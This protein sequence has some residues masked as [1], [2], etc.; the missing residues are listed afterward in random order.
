MWKKVLVITFKTIVYILFLA[1]L[2]A[3]LAKTGNMPAAMPKEY[4]AK[5]VEWTDRTLFA[6]HIIKDENVIK[7]YDE[8]SPQVKQFKT[9]S[10]LLIKR[11]PVSVII[12]YIL[13]NGYDMKQENTLNK[14]SLGWNASVK[15]HLSLLDNLAENPYVRSAL[16]ESQTGMID[17]FTADFLNST[18]KDFE[19]ISGF[20]IKDKTDK[21][22]KFVKNKEL[23]LSIQDLAKKG[24]SGSLTLSYLKG[25]NF[26]LYEYVSSSQDMKILFLLQP[27][28]FSSIP[29]EV[30]P[31][32]SLFLFNDEN[33][34]ISSRIEEAGLMNKIEESLGVK[35]FLYRSANY[36]ISYLKLSKTEGLYLGIYYKQYPVWKIVLNTVKF[37]VVLTTI[38][39]IVLLT[40]VFIK[41]VLSYRSRTKKDE[42]AMI[43]GAMMEVAK[44][45]KLAAGATEKASQFAQFETQNVKQI[46]KELKNTK[47]LS[48]ASEIASEETEPGENQ[49]SGGWKLID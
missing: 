15:K 30:V 42:M 8:R 29:F 4:A 38:V 23:D 47:V 12:N 21:V 18:I 40:R 37:L 16:L 25:K 49:D 43:T 41:K 33:K 9:T 27:S 7:K 6:L 3:V 39:I 22:I 36:N 1:V 48:K 28:Y 32:S 14:I 26:F 44:S 11:N 45:I 13:F 24:I 46:I 10:Q 5:I 2:L 35:H 20:V 19:M 31:S 17:T 34:L